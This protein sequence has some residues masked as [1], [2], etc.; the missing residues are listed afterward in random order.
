M[1]K[2]KVK[3]NDMVE[4]ISGADKGKRG[5]V[6]RVIPERSRVL[7]EKVKVMKRHTRPSSARAR[8][9]IV[10]REAPIQISNVMVVCTKC[11]RAGRVGRKSLA[12]GKKVRYCR[13][14]GEVLD[15]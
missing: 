1:L 13:N 10:E 12:D 11:N 7:V 5:K 6:V 8:G 4:V 3:K 9:G 14:C 2:L 15:V